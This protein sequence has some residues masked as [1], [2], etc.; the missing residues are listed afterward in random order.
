MAVPQGQKTGKAPTCGASAFRRR[1]S[2]YVLA[3]IATIACTMIIGCD[4]T[5]TSST[6]GLTATLGPSLTPYA[7]ATTPCQ[8]RPCDVE[9]FYLTIVN[10]NPSVPLQGFT[11]RI[12]S[13]YN[14][15]AASLSFTND[16]TGTTY[17]DPMGLRLDTPQE[18]AFPAA[19][20]PPCSPWSAPIPIP[21]GMNVM[22]T[23]CYEIAD[24]TL[25]RTYLIWLPSASGEAWRIRLPAPAS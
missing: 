21:R 23:A 17:A 19:L 16:T 10:D 9:N 6:T 15:L 1:R 12:P 14:V 20:G 24:Y 22:I 11:A 8:P 18:E 7:S 3:L 13:G 5:G 25:G 2:V 4:G